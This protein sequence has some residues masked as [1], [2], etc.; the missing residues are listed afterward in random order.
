[1]ALKAVAFVS[2]C[3]P[4][5]GECASVV[6]AIAFEFVLSTAAGIEVGAVGPASDGTGWWLGA[7]VLVMPKSLAGGALAVGVKPEVE[8]ALGESPEVEQAFQGIVCLGGPAMEST[9]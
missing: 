1:M 5:N 2:S 9:A 4:V 8:G 3:S 7:V 6:E